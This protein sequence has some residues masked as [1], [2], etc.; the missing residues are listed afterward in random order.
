[1]TRQ[2]TS[3]LFI[4]LRRENLDSHHELHFLAQSRDALEAWTC[5]SRVSPVFAL[6]SA[7]PPDLSGK[8]RNTVCFL[9]PVYPAQIP[10]SLRAF[11]TLGLYNILI[12]A[13]GKAELEQLEELLHRLAGKYAWERWDL[14]GNTVREISFGQKK[15]AASSGSNAWAKPVAHQLQSSIDEYQTLF[16]TTVTR[17]GN[18]LDDFGADFTTFDA[19]FRATL[20]SEH[21]RKKK[22]NT[23]Q[24]HFSEQ[25]SQVISVN[26]ALSRY[27][28]QTFAGI[29]PITE[30]ECHFW[31]HSLLGAGTATGALVAIRD[32]IRYL[33]QIA[34][35]EARIEGCKTRQAPASTVFD[36]SS[37]W[38]AKPLE[39]DD[40]ADYDDWV[41]FV[42]FFSGRDGFKSTQFTMSVP[43]E[44]VKG[45]NT[46]EWSLQTITHEMSHW[47]VE[48]ILASLVTKDDIDGLEWSTRVL[49]M[50]NKQDDAT[51]VQP[52]EKTYLV[53]T[54]AYGLLRI[55]A[56]HSDGTYPRVQESRQ[57]GATLG[58]RG[59]KTVN[60]ASMKCTP[61]EL[62]EIVRSNWGEIE[63]LFAHIFDFYYFYKSDVAT[64]LSGIW[65]SWDIIPNNGG[66]IEQYLV[67]CLCAIYLNNIS[68]DKSLELTVGK[69]QGELDQLAKLTNENQYISDAAKNLRDNKNQYLDRLG[70][71]TVIV[72]LAKKLMCNDSVAQ[73]LNARG[74]RPTSQRSSPSNASNVPLRF[75]SNRQIDNPLRFI[76]ELVKSDKADARMSAWIMTQLAF[77]THDAG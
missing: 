60:A 69:L 17:G 56:E 40:D 61:K 72:R 30:T 77:A 42:V 32:H 35:F 6:D 63:E 59:V 34:K 1:V 58:T 70:K 64:Y 12:V 16:A 43:L 67:R 5:H 2:I 27:S 26:A 48:R 10:I 52:D 73:S 31:T 23:Q 66:K 46:H 28:S 65:R 20:N 11:L 13:S 54:L 76:D 3:E 21:P 7:F 4:H 55:D 8:K 53:A 38:W 33:A 44:C 14:Q 24:R 18:Y 15:S 29:S 68:M 49:K 9:G 19:A 39:L 41:P 57:F 75:I 36:A 50:L 45:A 25:L 22:K 74:V 47:F 37:E 71:R 62:Q 51:S